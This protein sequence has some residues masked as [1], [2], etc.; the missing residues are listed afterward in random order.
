MQMYRI[1]C[2]NHTHSAGWKQDKERTQRVDG[3]A[4]RLQKQARITVRSHKERLQQARQ[5]T[6]AVSFLEYAPLKQA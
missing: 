1:I 3:T 6:L 2:T 5:K 4:L